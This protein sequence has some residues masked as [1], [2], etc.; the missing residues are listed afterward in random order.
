MGSAFYR[1]LILGFC[2]TGAMIRL[3]FYPGETAARF[4]D[5]FEGI[6]YDFRLNASLPDTPRKFNEEVVIIDIDD[7]SIREQG[8]FPWSRAKMALLV[9]KLMD[10]GVVVATFDIY[11]SEPEENPVDL[12]FANTKA[13]NTTTKK[14]LLA[15]KNQIDGDDIFAKTLANSEV[16][17]GFLFHQDLESS[18]GGKPATTINWQPPES[19]QDVLEH[20]QAYSSNINKLQTAASGEGY[21]NAQSDDDGIIREASLVIR[22]Q[23]KLYPSLALET[24]RIYSLIESI[25]IRSGD[26]DGL[27][28]LQQ[29]LL[30][31]HWIDTDDAGRILIPYKGPKRSFPYYSAT[32]VLNGVIG[33]K[34]LEGS[35]AFIGTSTVG[36]ADLRSTPVGAQYPGV[37]VHANV[38]EGLLHPEILASQPNWSYGALF[39]LLLVSGVFMSIVFPGRGP[40]FIVGLT[41]F[42]L[43]IHIA[44]NWYLWI[45]LRV[46]LPLYLILCLVAF[47]GAYYVVL[48]FF[49]ETTKRKAIKD[50]FNQYVP[51]QH[52]DTLIKL[53]KNA[54]VETQRREMSV[55]FADIRN[56]TSL[57]ENLSPQELSEFLNAYLSKATEIIFDN[58]GTID[59]YVGDMVMA[60]W[61]APLDDAN[62]A[63]N[64][65]KTALDILV[66]VEQMNLKFHEQGWPRINIGVGISTGVMN[67]GDMGSKYR[68]A[69]T[70]LGDAVNLGSRLE[71][72]TKFYGIEILVG[73]QAMSHA[74]GII[75]RYVDTV[76]VVGKNIATAIYEPLTLELRMTEEHKTVLKLHD[77]AMK[78]YK[79][80]KWRLCRELLEELML[81][82]IVT[83]HLY[84]VYLA[85]V[86]KLET[87]EL[88]PDWDGVMIHARK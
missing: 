69:Y 27:Q 30:K 35:V 28:V 23:D 80:Q 5:R 77:R 29:V 22:H 14:R 68:K 52:I 78:A 64:A 47:L 63:T 36:L 17:L 26:L 83:T 21:I 31:D 40:G 72:L 38:F 20:Y 37:E 6:I 46:S 10:A 86:D 74:K 11:F 60:F 87:Q 88:A 39:T 75:F 66:Q 16:V 45:A 62:H 55:L 54:E 82:D 25:E 70:V 57:S 1:N 24:A 43:A 32:D 58:H 51:P 2:L 79:N 85:R 59:K 19:G 42:I 33:E 76:K 41:V 50:M 34:E 53:G 49:V 48:G 4:L 67:V 12:I 9:N 61:N 81:Q 65:I 15:I 13:I 71:S 84:G 44:L 3:Q 18:I 8:Q 73:Y 56:F 7:K